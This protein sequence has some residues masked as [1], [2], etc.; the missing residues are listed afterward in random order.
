MEIA[1]LHIPMGPVWSIEETIKSGR[2]HKA[3]VFEVGGDK[4]GNGLSF[5]GSRVTFL[6]GSIIQN[7]GPGYQQIYRYD[8]QFPYIIGE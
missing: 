7:E 4:K 6:G 1:H 2:G 8:G 5:L 3:L